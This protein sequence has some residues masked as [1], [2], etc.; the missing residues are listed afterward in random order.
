MRQNGRIGRIALAE[1]AEKG[2]FNSQ[3]EITLGLLRFLLV[4]EVQQ[5]PKRKQKLLLP[6]AFAQ[7]GTAAPIQLAVVIEAENDH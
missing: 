6:V 3:K 5:E 1:S 7:S 2:N 4:K